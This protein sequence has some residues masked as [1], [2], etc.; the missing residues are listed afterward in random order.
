MLHWRCQGQVTMVGR[1]V[2]RVGQRWV[3]VLMMGSLLGGW[4]L[5]AAWGQE[6][7]GGMKLIMEELRAV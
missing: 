1:I 4:Y 6:L 3:V 2:H 5:P 7:T